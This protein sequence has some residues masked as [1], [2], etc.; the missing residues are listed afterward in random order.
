MSAASRT[1]VYPGMTPR[2]LSSP[3]SKSDCSVRKRSCFISDSVSEAL[4]SPIVNISHLPDLLKIISEVGNV[5][6]KHLDDLD[7]WFMF[8]KREVDVSSGAAKVNYYL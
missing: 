7:C 1:G 5:E 6:L 3:N 8:L 2:L 4:F